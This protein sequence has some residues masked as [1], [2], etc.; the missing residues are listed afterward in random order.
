MVKTRRMEKKKKER[1]EKKN[2]IREFT[3]KL[4]RLTIENSTAFKDAT[5]R[6]FGIRDLAVKIERYLPQASKP[7]T[8]RLKLVTTS[9]NQKT[10]RSLV[11][12]LPTTATVKQKSIGEYMYMTLL[13]SNK[14]MKFN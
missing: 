5:F 11:P 6:M 13:L 7:C 10:V 3:I 9:S 4:N 14:A 8:P 12:W 2:G 1:F